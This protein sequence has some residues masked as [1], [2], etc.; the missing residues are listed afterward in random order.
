[1]HHT[2]ATDDGGY[3]GQYRLTCKRCNHLRSWLVLKPIK[4]LAVLDSNIG[5]VEGFKE[6]QE[7]SGKS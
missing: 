4:N 7:K 1:M 6:K 5:V 2:C 3:M